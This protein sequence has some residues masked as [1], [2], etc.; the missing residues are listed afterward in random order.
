VFF[1]LADV[2]VLLKYRFCYFLFTYGFVWLYKKNLTLRNYGRK[3][4]PANEIRVV[5]FGNGGAKK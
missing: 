5:V 1:G 2:P 3:T 4:K